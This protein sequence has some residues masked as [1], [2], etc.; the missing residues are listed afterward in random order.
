MPDERILGFLFGMIET[1]Y[2]GDHF[3]IREM[4]VAPSAQRRGSGSRL[5]Q[6][7]ESRL[8]KECQRST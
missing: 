8:R 2:D 6:E 7:A 3:C 1:F 4:A 5:L